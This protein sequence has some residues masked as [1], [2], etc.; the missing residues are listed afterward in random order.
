MK[1]SQIYTDI[2][3]IIDKSHD[4]LSTYLI[5]SSSLI[6]KSEIC[7]IGATIVISAYS[8]TNL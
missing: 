5:L 8:Y 4:T 3:L 2:V 6:S 7:L 1:T